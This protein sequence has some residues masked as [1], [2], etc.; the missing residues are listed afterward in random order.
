MTTFDPLHHHA[1]LATD[2]SGYRDRVGG[3]GAYCMLIGSPIRTD[4]CWGGGLNT[5]VYRMELTG[6][7]EGLKLAFDMGNWWRERGQARHSPKRI[8]WRTDSESLAGAVRLD[9]NGQPT[10]LREGAEDLFV[11]LEYFEQFCQ[12]EPVWGGREDGLMGLPDWFA[13]NTRTVL[14]RMREAHDWRAVRDMLAEDAK[15]KP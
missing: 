15:T 11:R 14:L 13:S 7:L 12:I 5:S 2:G 6:L 4:F 1:L 9:Q 10:S 3:W 8:W